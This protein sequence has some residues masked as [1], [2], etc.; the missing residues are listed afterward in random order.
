MRSH[1]GVRQQ[2]NKIVVPYLVT[3]NGTH[4]LVF[5][6]TISKGG[7]AR[8]S[9]DPDEALHNYGP[10]ESLAMGLSISK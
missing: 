4:S 3:T 10:V 1:R 6:V 9:A 7:H 8:Y 2:F 5:R